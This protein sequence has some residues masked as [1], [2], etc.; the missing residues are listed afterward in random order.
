VTSRAF[1]YLP[2]KLFELSP[3]GGGRFYT[4]LQDAFAARGWNVAIR[5]RYSIHA[6]PEYDA[7]GVH[8]V[9]QGLVRQP[10]VFNTAIA[11]IAP[12]WY[13]D[14]RGVFGESSIGDMVFDAAAEDTADARAFFERLARRNIGRRLTK[15]PQPGVSPDIPQGCIA[16]FLQG[17]SQ[18]VERA[19][20]CSEALMV[21]RIAAA[22]NGVPVIIK[23]HPRNHDPATLNA[24]AR[25][26]DR[27]PNVTLIDAHVHDMLAACRV[28][29]SISSAVSLEGMMHGKP[30]I[31]FGKTD[32]HHIAQTVKAAGDVRAALDSATRSAPPFAA[33]LH[34]FLQKQCINMGREGWFDRILARVGASQ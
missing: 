23:Q 24:V 12:F 1:I 21:E 3:P 25:I 7:P 8:F 10:R 27:H 5:Q 11:Y 32:F 14:P 6:G 20:H 19:Q 28:T 33:Y 13:V 26:K 30:A 18:P 2:K 34:W 4:K 15:Y 9:H 17:P 16:V 31:L 22:S 29:C